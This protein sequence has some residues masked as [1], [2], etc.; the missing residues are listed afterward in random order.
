MKPKFE[1]TL[2]F[3]VI[4]KPGEFPVRVTLLGHYKS[5]VFVDHVVYE[6]WVGEV[7]ILRG[8]KE[9]CE[10]WVAKEG[11]PTIH[12]DIRPAPAWW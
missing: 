3:P 12:Y 7:R 4:S 9:E 2:G 11:S 8:S 10:D 6:I 1:Q 5:D